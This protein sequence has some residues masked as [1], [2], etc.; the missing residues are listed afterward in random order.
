MGTKTLNKEYKFLVWKADSKCNPI[1]NTDRILI[2]PSKR[3]IFNYLATEEKIKLNL[4]NGT[5]LRLP[6]GEMWCAVRI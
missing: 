3:W 4:H 6:N 1:E 5:V 2:G